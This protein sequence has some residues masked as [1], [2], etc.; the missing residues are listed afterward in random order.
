VIER[1][2]LGRSGLEVPIIGMG[3]WRTF[4]THEDRRPL[5]DAALGMGVDLFDSSPMYGRAEDA[6]AH[7]LHGRREKALIATKVWTA[8]PSEGR[9]QA[10]NALRLYGHIDVYQVHNLVNWQAQLALLEEL[11]QQGK[12]RV[13]GATHYQPSAFGELASLMR[14]G[15]LEMVQLPYNPLRR[16]AERELLPLAQE[17]GL[18][19]LVMSPLQHGVMDRDPGARRLQRLGVESWPEAVLKWIAAE[20]RVSCVLT[21]TTRIDHLEQNV[22]AGNGPWPDADWRDQVAAIAAGAA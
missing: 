11:K 12:V 8:D 9:G 16:E 5:V 6:L 2:P 4:D 20:P 15:R 14:S 13:I 10:E 21:A 19:V 17:L 18:G 3:T 1:R 7:A 22:R